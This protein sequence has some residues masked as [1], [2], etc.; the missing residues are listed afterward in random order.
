[1]K[2]SGSKS[3]R[4]LSRTRRSRTRSASNSGVKAVTVKVVG[5]EGCPYCQKLHALFHKLGIT[6]ELD[7]VDN[8]NAADQARIVQLIQETGH[9]TVPMIWI[10]K[11]F[12]GGLDDFLDYATNV[13]VEACL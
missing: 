2:R 6:Y 10:N 13:L 8:N 3:R 1:M 11:T 12:I 9:K 5:R 4:K 7:N